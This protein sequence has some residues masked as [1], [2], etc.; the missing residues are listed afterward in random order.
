MTL[1]PKFI[2]FD[3]D[4]T[5]LDHKSAERAALKDAF[6]HYSFFN[7]MALDQL[8]KTYE[9]INAKLWDQYNHGKIDRDELQRNR[10]K[11]TL[12]QLDLDGDKYEEVGS[13]YMDCYANHWQWMDG[14]SKAYDR[15]RSHFQVGVITNGFSE[16]QKKKFNRFDLHK[17]ANHLIISEDVGVMKPQPGIFKYAT[18]LAD[19]DPDDILY[20]GDSYN[21]DIQG[22]SSY[23]WNTAWYKSDPD[24]EISKEADFIFAEFEDLCELLEV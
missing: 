6:E 10:F 9:L 3:L 7:G 16:T 17:T 12:E 13:Y 19:C 1:N 18:E 5:L 23:G 21:S 24:P 20:V 22:G 4:D 15:I 14:A 2:Y 8:R 11:Y